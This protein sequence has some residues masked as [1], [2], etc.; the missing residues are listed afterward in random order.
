MR[1]D[2]YEYVC[3]VLKFLY[4]R[5][6]ESEKST[7]CTIEQNG[8]GFNAVDAPILSSFTTQILKGATLSEK[9][10][11]IAKK[12]LPKYAKQLGTLIIP[13]PEVPNMTVVET[14]TK[15][16]PLALHDGYITIEVPYNDIQKRNYVKNL[17]FRWIPAEKHWKG[18]DNAV[19]RLALG[20]PLDEVQIDSSIANQVRE[21]FPHARDYQILDIV[22]MIS[23]GS[24]INANEMGLGK[25]FEAIVAISMM[26]CKKILIVCPKTLMYNWQ[27]EFLKWTN[28]DNNSINLIQGTP[29]QKKEALCKVGMSTVNIINYD[30]I[31][32]KQSSMGET[33]EVLV[34]LQS[35]EWDV[36]VADEA[37][38]IKNRTRSR[39]AGLKSLH[40]THK[41]ALTGTPVQNRP[42][43]LWSIM[44]WV[45]PFYSTNSYWKFVYQFCEIE[46]NGFG[47]Q[48]VGLTTNNDRLKMLHQI[49][50][51]VMIRNVKSEVLKELPD[52]EHQVLKIAM[53]SKQRK[54]YEVLEKEILLELSSGKE[55]NI[56]NTLTRL[57]RLQQMTSS[58][59][60][61]EI[62]DNPKA[63]VA[64]DLIDGS[65]S[66][67]LVFSRFKTVIQQFEKTLEKAG[68]KC[69]SIT[70]DTKDRQQIVDSFQNDPE[71]R[72]FLGTIRAAGEGITLTA[73]DKVIFLD[74][75]WSPAMNAQA[76]DRVHRIGQKNAVTIYDIQCSGSIDTWV[77]QVLNKK[78]EDIEALLQS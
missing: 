63:E 7:D 46:D 26:N 61:F 34:A 40:S 11:N 55:V 53:S 17:G 50:S 73:A 9:Q 67:F 29:K 66:K 75:E 72:V 37:H 43:D 1:L 16:S 65:D 58:P 25:T 45:N 57:L 68:V 44:H 41:M 21:R 23:L 24:S 78:N 13:E 59:E 18:L 19:H 36:I 64:L 31:G 4:A 39:T 30:I 35:Y 48:I 42:N 32:S 71:I 74:R 20:I 51:N 8:S 10:L 14:E 56:T 28:I 15:K 69:V 38:R 33:N 47:A 49:N 5:Q 22:R 60:L 70:G 54:A 12:L 76:E 77:E 2:N 62:N 52:K 6:T 27:N 3:E